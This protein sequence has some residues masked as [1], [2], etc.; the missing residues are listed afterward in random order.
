MHNT[1]CILKICLMF[2]LSFILFP[3]F[4]NHLQ[5]NSWTFPG[6]PREWPACEQK[7]RERE[8]PLLAETAA[9]A[10]VD[11]DWTGCQTV[12]IIRLESG[13]VF[14]GRHGDGA[15][16]V[17]DVTATVAH[18]G[19]ATAGA[20]PSTT[21]S[22]LS[23]TSFCGLEDQLRRNRFRGRAE[24]PTK[25]VLSTLPF[26]TGSWSQVEMV[27][28]ERDGLGSWK[29]C[30]VPTGADELY[31]SITDTTTEQAKI[32]QKADTHFTI[33]RWVEGWVK[34]VGWLRTEMVYLPADSHPSK[35]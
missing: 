5:K 8:L 21:T 12:P 14:H 4:S 13:K 31:A 28:C 25:T 34:L 1:D 33:P 23:T 29:L 9:A 10:V 24:F 2:I 16:A 22:L 26:S 35:Y 17:A 7:S 15:T 6:F 30:D 3:V 27:N 32:S 18:T 19:W 11:C 20:T